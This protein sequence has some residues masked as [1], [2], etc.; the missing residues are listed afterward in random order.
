MARLVKVGTVDDGKD[1]SAMYEARCGERDWPN[2][3]VGYIPL[4]PEESGDHQGRF[5][6]DWCQSGVT[7][8]CITR[9]FRTRSVAKKWMKIQAR[10][11]DCGR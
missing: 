4:T 3:A 10:K 2:H 8:R 1:G 5:S 9:Y 7:H 11:L 6:V